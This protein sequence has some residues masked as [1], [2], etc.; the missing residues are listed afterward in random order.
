MINNWFCHLDG[1][2]E[3]EAFLHSIDDDSVQNVYRGLAG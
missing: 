3:V 1:H 2:A